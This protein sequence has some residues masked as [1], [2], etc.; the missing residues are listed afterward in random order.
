MPNSHGHRTRPLDTFESSADCREGPAIPSRYLPMISVLAARSGPSG[1]PGYRFPRHIPTGAQHRIPSTPPQSSHQH[2]PMQ[3]R[4]PIA[5]TPPP[6]TAPCHPSVPHHSSIRAPS[7]AH[8][9]PPHP[10]CMGP[11]WPTRFP[12]WMPGWRALSTRVG[13]SG[14]L[15]CAML[16]R[17]VPH[18]SPLVGAVRAPHDPPRG[19]HG[20][21]AWGHQGPRWRPARGPVEPICRRVGPLLARCGG[22]AV[23]PL[24]HYLEKVRVDLSHSWGQ[25]DLHWAWKVES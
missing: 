23:L 3:A 16:A 10:P 2:A 7:N 20:R 22:P 15:V 14:C 4:P 13:P 8:S 6:V 11:A 5:A 12:C 1:V 25:A 9:L 21:I 18:A 24:G 19:A 17:H